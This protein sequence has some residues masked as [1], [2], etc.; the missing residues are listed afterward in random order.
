MGGED[1]GRY[2]TEGEPRVPIFMYRL[3]SVPAERVAESMRDGGRPLPSL[4]SSK[5]LPVRE[6]IKTGVTTMTAA[7]V[8]LLK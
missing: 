5:Y 3:G 8:D 7:A 2:G 1:F 4:H 6:A